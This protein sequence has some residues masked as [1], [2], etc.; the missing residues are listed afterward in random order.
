MKQGDLIRMIP[1]TID[2]RPPQWFGIV[3]ETGIPLFEGD[4]CGDLCT[5]EA[6]LIHWGSNGIE[7]ISVDELEVVSEKR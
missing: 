6:V 2:D 3:L 1:W 7:R 4:D 5:P